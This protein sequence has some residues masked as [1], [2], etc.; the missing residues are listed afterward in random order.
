LN[1]TNEIDCTEMYPLIGV[2]P[3]L[4]ERGGWAAQ[5]APGGERSGACGVSRNM[6]ELPMLFFPWPMGAD[7]LVLN[8][9]LRIAMDFLQLTGQAQ[10]YETAQRRAASSILAAYRQGVRHPIRLGNCGIGAVENDQAV[11]DLQSFYPRVS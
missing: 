10:N 1:W 7:D 8:Q 5:D 3:R 4:P 9:S 11:Q 2:T 6:S